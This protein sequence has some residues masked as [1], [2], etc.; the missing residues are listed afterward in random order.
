M[1]MKVN[2]WRLNSRNRHVAG[3]NH[4]LNNMQTTKRDELQKELL[5]ALRD[6]IQEKR[7]DIESGM[8]DGTYD[9][10]PDEGK[11]DGHNTLLLEHLDELDAAIDEFEN[12][13]PTIYIM[14]EGG[15]VQGASAN[16][17]IN[18]DIFDV[19]NYKAIDADDKEMYETPEERDE[20]IKAKTAAG[21]IKPVY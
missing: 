16:C 19:D 21:T 18:V 11:E 7:E 20:M 9:D 17:S 5:I 10:E 1:R 2:W 15:N 14:V 8:G 13:Q 4:K 6:L 12:E 3:I